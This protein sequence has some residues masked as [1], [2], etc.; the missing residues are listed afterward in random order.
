MPLN[1]FINKL[2]FAKDGAGGGQFHRVPVVTAK[3][4]QADI[5][6]R[7]HVFQVP[8][9]AGGTLVI[10]QKVRQTP[11]AH[12]GH[13]AVLPAQVEQ[14]KAGQPGQMNG[15]VD[16]RFYFR[17]DSG[18]THIYGLA[19]VPCRGNHRACDIKTERGKVDR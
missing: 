8:P 1:N 9:R 6:H 2:T 4:F 14:G 12:Q 19:A 3:F 17:D 7:G 16:V 13:L 11:P 5:Q 10:G 18:V 15:A